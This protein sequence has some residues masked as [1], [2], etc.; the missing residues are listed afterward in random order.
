M[1][2]RGGSHRGNSAVQPDGL[3][4]AKL[5][6]GQSKHSSNF[7]RAMESSAVGWE[8]RLMLDNVHNEEIETSRSLG[9]EILVF[10]CCF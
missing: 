3:C 2:G 8:V 5:R 6:Q 7:S 4:G 1:Q 9:V 10:I